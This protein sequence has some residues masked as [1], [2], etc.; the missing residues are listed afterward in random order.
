[1]AAKKV[2]IDEKKVEE[3]IERGV[4]KLENMDC[5]GKKKNKMSSAG[6]VGWFWFTGF[7][8]AVVYFW[9]YVNSFGTGVFAIVKAI[10]WPAFLVL[11][12]FK[13]LRI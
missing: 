1:M 13:F 12:L 5:S 9:Q 8:G 11:H 3:W 4:K 7:I 6:S 2:T 10:A